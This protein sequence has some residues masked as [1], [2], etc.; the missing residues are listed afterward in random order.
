MKTIYFHFHIFSKFSD[1]STASV[2]AFSRA[3]SVCQ[4][5]WPLPKVSL[6]QCDDSSFL[7]VI[8][9][10]RQLSICPRIIAGTAHSINS[11]HL[12][13]LKELRD[14]RSKRPSLSKNTE[15]NVNYKNPTFPPTVRKEE[16]AI[17]TGEI[18]RVDKTTAPSQM[19]AINETSRFCCFAW[20]KGNLIRIIKRNF[21]RIGEYG[22]TRKSCW[23]KLVQLCW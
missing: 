20:V 18:P 14:A 8:V 19:A 4:W 6:W 17:I 12:N 23:N 22:A 13:C 15:K 11:D 2:P 21:S 9:R 16:V 10:L 3:G 1:M 5:T 7:I